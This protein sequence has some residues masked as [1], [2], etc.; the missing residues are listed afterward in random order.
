ML[1][2]KQELQKELAELLLLT[3]DAAC[4]KFAKEN[5]VEFVLIKEL[6]ARMAGM[7]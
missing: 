7:V 1:P 4:L 5:M 6:E 2:L 3:S